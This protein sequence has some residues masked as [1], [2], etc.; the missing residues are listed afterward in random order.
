MVRIIKPKNS[1]I[2]HEFDMSQWLELFDCAKRDHRK[3]NPFDIS[4]LTEKVV[5]AKD[6]LQTHYT[7]HETPQIH[8]LH[9]DCIPIVCHYLSIKSLNHVIMN[10]KI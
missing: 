6:K 4:A 8:R 5:D 7:C 9:N 2:Y 10:V 1:E 3:N